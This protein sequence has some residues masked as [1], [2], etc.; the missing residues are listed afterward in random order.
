MSATVRVLIGTF[1]HSEV[2]VYEVDRAGF[3]AQARRNDA[4]ADTAD[5]IMRRGREVFRTSYEFAYGIGGEG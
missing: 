2:V 4:D 1:D 3:E 5:W